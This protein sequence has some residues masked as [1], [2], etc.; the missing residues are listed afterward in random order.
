[1]ES[2]PLSKDELIG[3]TVHINH[4]T[5]PTMDHM[6]GVIIDETKQ[7]F[8]IESQGKHRWIAKDIATFVFPIHQKK[9]Q[10]NGS[11]LKFRPEERVKKAR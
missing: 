8:L 6:K 5:D 3:K 2:I 11:K 1:M 4:C 7:M 9:I 10:I